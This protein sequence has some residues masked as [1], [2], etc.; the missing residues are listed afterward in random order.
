MGSTTTTVTRQVVIEE[1]KKKKDGL[2]LFL[3]FS[4]FWSLRL[5]SFLPSLLH[6]SASSLLCHTCVS[7]LLFLSSLPASEGDER[8][9]EEAEAEGGWV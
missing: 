8:A 5:P 9:A 2:V 6:S 3:L 7:S 4:T 1:E